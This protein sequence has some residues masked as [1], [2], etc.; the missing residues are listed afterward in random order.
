MGIIAALSRVVQTQHEQLNEI[1][2]EMA[3]S[4]VVQNSYTSSLQD[5]TQTKTALAQKLDRPWWP[6]SVIAS[7][8]WGIITPQV[9]RANEVDL[10]DIREAAL[11]GLVWERRLQ[12]LRGLPG[13]TDVPAWRGVSERFRPENKE[14]ARERRLNE[15]ELASVWSAGDDWLQALNQRTFR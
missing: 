1:F 14:A 5:A 6:T 9:K 2:A 13:G 4:T 12:L 15:D 10:P 8:T 7:S 11:E 3:S